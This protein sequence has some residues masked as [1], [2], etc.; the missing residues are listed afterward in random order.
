MV[1]STWESGMR[2]LILPTTLIFPLHFVSVPNHRDT[3]CLVQECI[4]EI[5]QQKVVFVRPT[6]S[7]PV[8]GS[9]QAQLLFVGG[10]CCFLI[11]TLCRRERDKLD[12]TNRLAQQPYPRC[13]SRSGGQRRVPGG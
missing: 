6:G 8:A 9:V 5:W 3:C 13:L 12:K 11:Y 2:L 10:G 4:L 1:L 7:F